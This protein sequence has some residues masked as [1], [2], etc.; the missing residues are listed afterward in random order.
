MFGYLRP[1]REEL[2]VREYDLYQSVYCGLCRRLG[3]DYGLLARFTLSYDCTLLA[4][5]SLSLKGESSCVNE[6]RCVFN[7]MK[8]CLFCSGSADSFQL[9]GAVSVIMTYDK[10]Q[11]TI[12]D[13]GFWKRTAARLLRLT[14]RRSYR[15]AKSAYPQLAQQAELMLQKQQQAE[16]SDCG[17]DAAAAPTADFLSYICG[18][19]AGDDE[20]QRFVLEKFGYF[21]GRW[22]YLI[23]AADDFEDDLHRQLFN[24]FRKHQK[25]TPEQTMLYCNGVLNMTASQLLLAFDLL[26]LHGYEEIL[27][28]V[29]RLGLS[30][31]QK[32]CLFDKKQHKKCRHKKQDLYPFLSDGFHP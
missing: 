8:K 9:A 25:E 12:S 13:S 17:I 28:N 16:T 10:L 20:K 31:Q 11:D 1:V 32:Y 26:S 14:L 18:T 4:M 5:L 30:F 7:P 2:K 3:K 23:D 22:I 27:D 29:I 19:L 21:L 24:P 6:G 15:K